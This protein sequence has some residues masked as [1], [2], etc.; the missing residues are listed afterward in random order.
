VRT[1]AIQRVGRGATM[2]PAVSADAAHMRQRRRCGWTGWARSAASTAR[3]SPKT[4]A[5]PG[6]ATPARRQARQLSTRQH[7]RSTTQS[8]GVGRSG[9]EHSVWHAPAPRSGQYTHRGSGATVGSRRAAGCVVP[10]SRP[11]KARRERPQH[12]RSTPDQCG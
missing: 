10:S 1:A 3:R 4:R 5:T 6:T 7:L 9:L 2:S 11:T 8:S 12:S